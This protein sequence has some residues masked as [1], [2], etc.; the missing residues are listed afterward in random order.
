MVRSEKASVL[1]CQLE[2]LEGNILKAFS[3]AAQ[4][5]GIPEEAA[6]GQGICM[7]DSRTCSPDLGSASGST[8]QPRVAEL[9][10]DANIQQISM[11]LG[12]SRVQQQLEQQHE[13]LTQLR[14]RIQQ[15]ELQASSQLPLA[16]ALSCL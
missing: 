2:M 14:R 1:T 8:K 6:L 15:L 5:Q 4:Q 12:E 9:N 16:I 10:A 3:E 7:G 13:A 11:P